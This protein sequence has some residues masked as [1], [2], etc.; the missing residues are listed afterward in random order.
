M[1]TS[2]NAVAVDLAEACRRLGIG[3]SSGKNL[4]S[5]GALRTI[6]CGRRRLIPV[7]EL[8]RWVTHQLAAS[9]PTSKGAA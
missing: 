7:K 3:L 9:E 8:D 1:E 4:V 2:S 5:S 6:R